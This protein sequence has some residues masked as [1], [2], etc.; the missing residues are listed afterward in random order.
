[1]STTTHRTLYA[2]FIYDPT[3]PAHRSIG[4]KFSTN[5]KFDTDRR[6]KNKN[7]TPS[8]SHIFPPR[9]VLWMIF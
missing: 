6:K 4:M 7:I 8:S 1:M 9:T 5:M 3:T 2:P